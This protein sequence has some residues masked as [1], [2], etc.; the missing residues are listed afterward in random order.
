[1][2]LRGE[3][4]ISYTATAEKQDGRYQQ[5]LYDIDSQIWVLLVLKEVCVSCSL[6][7]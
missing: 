3:L 1:M 7:T 5:L 6:E 2:P 4:L